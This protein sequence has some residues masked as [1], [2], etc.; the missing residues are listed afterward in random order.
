MIE[1]D[2]LIYIPFGFRLVLESRLFARGN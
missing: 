1:N 2:G